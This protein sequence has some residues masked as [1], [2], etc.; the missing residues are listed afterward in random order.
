MTWN[1]TWFG[2]EGGGGGGGGFALVLSFSPLDF[3][4]L[5]PDVARWT[6]IVVLVEVRTGDTPMCVYYPT[7]GLPQVV[8]DADIGYL[9]FFAGKSSIVQQSDPSQFLLT[10]L[11]NGGWQTEQFQL[12]FFSV[13]D[14]SE[15]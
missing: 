2:P 12:K 7:T 13:V 15:P 11:P 9:P 6:P 10:I 8:Y 3:T 4:S 1:G 5:D 14:M